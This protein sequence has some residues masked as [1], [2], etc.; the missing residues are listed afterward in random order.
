VYRKIDGAQEG[1]LASA[2]SPKIAPLARRGDPDADQE[3]WL[4]H[5]DDIRF[6]NIVMR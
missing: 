3:T 5:Y 6:G 1:H 4:I 2:R